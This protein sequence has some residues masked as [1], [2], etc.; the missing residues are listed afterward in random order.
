MRTVGV[1]LAADPAAT[2]LARI[3]WVPGRAFVRQLVVGVDD[4]AIVAAMRQSIDKVGIDCPLGWPTAFVEFVSAHHAG[5]LTAPAEVAERAGRRRLAYRVTDEVTHQVVGRW[6]LSVSAD[7]IGHA[8][9]R[10]AGL[11]AR[12]AR[13]GHPVDRSG[14][15]VVVEVYPAAALMLW[16]LPHRR[17]KGRANLP[18]LA[19]LVDRLLAEADRLHLGDFQA[20]C[21][22]S[23]HAVDAV[24]AAL[25]ARAAGCGLV[26]RP[27]PDQLGAASTEGWIALPTSPLRDLVA[28]Q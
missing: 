18:R 25:T 10:A 15:G 13:D 22:T 9:M 5:L 4:D 20:L 11:L 14:D 7:R 26:R 17:Y 12:L 28:R 2:A 19:E 1:D 8:A 6:P 23:D 24:I 27:A 21:R 3:D 16:G